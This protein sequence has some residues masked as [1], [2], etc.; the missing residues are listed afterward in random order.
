MDFEESE[1]QKAIADMASRLLHDTLSDERRARLYGVLRQPNRAFD[2]DGWQALAGAGLL[3]LMV[4]EENGGSGLGMAE[5]GKVLEAQGAVAMPVP[6]LQNMV[7]ALPV[8]DRFAPEALQAEV[9]PGLLAGEKIATIA[10]PQMAFGQVT[11]A[12]AVAA[13]GG[14][15]KLSGTMHAVPY[16]QEADYILLSADLP[17]GQSIIGLLD[18]AGLEIDPGLAMSGEGADS[19]HLDGV[20]LPAA[21]TIAEGAQALAARAR[22]RD[23]ALTGIAA[24]QIGVLSET[25]RR[26]AEY[27]NERKQFGRPLG[28]FQAVAQQAADAFMVIEALRGLYWK[29]VVTCDEAG[30]A[31]LDAHAAKWWVAEAGHQVAHTALHLHGGI[32]Q[33]LEYPIHRYFLW[34]KH[35]G[36]IMG[37]TPEHLSAIGAIAAAEGGARLMPDYAIIPAAPGDTPFWTE[38]KIA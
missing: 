7:M 32:G 28:G 15:Y 36:M 12:H 6:L 26:T 20:H 13:D 31:A 34:A 9:M 5:A 8:L 2:A 33:D 21:R 23:W 4:S 16:A 25:L 37:S 19:L 22:L 11:R 17:D 27:T 14:G 35:L 18:R 3:G 38:G 1:D 29:A 24:L 10:A 30:D